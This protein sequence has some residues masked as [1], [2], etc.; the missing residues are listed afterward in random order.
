MRASS[1]W[2]GAVAV[3]GLPCIRQR[4]SLSKAGKTH[5]VHYRGPSNASPG[6]KTIALLKLHDLSVKQKLGDVSSPTHLSLFFF[7]SCGSMVNMDRVKRKLPSLLLDGPTTIRIYWA[8]R[9]RIEQRLR[10]LKKQ[11]PAKY[12]SLEAHLIRDLE[13]FEEAISD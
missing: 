12:Q 10:R 8:E 9:H 2:F 5:L 3:I 11:S 4:S 7:W 13:P 1:R 6:N